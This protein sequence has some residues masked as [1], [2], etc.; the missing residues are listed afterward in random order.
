MESE[1]DM[2]SA[3]G[4]RLW[5][6]RLAAEGKLEMAI[7]AMRTAAALDPLNAARQFDHAELL[8]R[9]ARTQSPYFRGKLWARAR[10]ATEHGQALEPTSA[11]GPV[12][13]ETIL[14]AELE[15]KTATEDRTPMEQLPIGATSRRHPDGLT[16]RTNRTAARPEPKGLRGKYRQRKNSIRF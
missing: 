12:L 14:L 8:I 3:E 15:D 11:V 4:N 2:T 10:T 5:A 13:Y 1:Y 9:F 7:E 16:G 6:E